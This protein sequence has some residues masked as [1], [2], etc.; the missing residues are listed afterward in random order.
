MDTYNKETILI[1]SSFIQFTNSGFTIIHTF[2]VIYY[3]PRAFHLLCCWNNQF[4]IVSHCILQTASHSWLLLKM[5]YLIQCRFHLLKK[6][7]IWRRRRRKMKSS[8]VTNEWKTRIE[9]TTAA[10]ECSA[11]SLACMQWPSSHLFWANHKWMVYCSA[12]GPL[13]HFSLVSCH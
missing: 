12:L 10:T 7:E 9:E 8:L 4:F 3:I 6:S 13:W 2:S 5:F 11:L 1:Y